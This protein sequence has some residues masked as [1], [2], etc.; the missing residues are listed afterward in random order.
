MAPLGSILIPEKK[1]ELFIDF[2]KQLTKEL[3]FVRFIKYNVQL[4]SILNLL[5]PSFL[6]KQN[7]SKKLP[8][9][10]SYF[11]LIITFQ[12]K[13]RLLESICQNVAFSQAL[14]L[15]IN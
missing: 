12:W 14:N 9:N 5:K 11:V 6:K 13:V 2:L 3:N 7:Y 1:T 8:L 15:Y 10:D 4:L